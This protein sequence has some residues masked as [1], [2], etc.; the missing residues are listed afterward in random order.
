MNERRATGGRSAHVRD[1]LDACKETLVRECVLPPVLERGPMAALRAHARK[2]CAIKIYAGRATGSAA[3]RDSL[4][5]ASVRVPVV[6]QRAKQ[7]GYA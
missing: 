7:R 4:P 5:L 6:D 2:I 1:L 3:R